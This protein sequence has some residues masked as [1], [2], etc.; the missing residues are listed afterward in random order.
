MEQDESENKTMVAVEMREEEMGQGE[1]KK[2]M[3]VETVV[4]T[5]QPMAT[6]DEKDGVESAV[7]EKRVKESDEEGKGEEEDVMGETWQMVQAKRQKLAAK[8]KKAKERKAKGMSVIASGEEKKAEV[9]ASQSV[10]SARELVMDVSN[11][12]LILSDEE[13][14][15]RLWTLSQLALSQADIDRA[16]V[17][18]EEA[19]PAL[20]TMLDVI[21]RLIDRWMAQCSSA[22]P[23]HSN[24]F[25]DRQYASD[26][27]CAVVRLCLTP[28]RF[29]HRCLSTALLSVPF[30]ANFVLKTSSSSSSATQQL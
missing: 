3:A 5:A 10:M 6:S 18:P 14:R 4:V 1:E 13:E 11:D 16:V 28:A 24:P 22:L 20:L 8:K 29:T 27:R 30:P 12:D 21:H 9:K 23:P 2:E 25:S 26:W 19:H 7:V 15:R 17:R